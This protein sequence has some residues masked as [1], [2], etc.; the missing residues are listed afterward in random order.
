VLIVVEILSVCFNLLYLLY[1]IRQ[2]P[3]TW[4][5]GVIA[6]LLSFYLFYRMEYPASAV[7]NIIY[8]LQGIFGFLQWEFFQKKRIPGFYLSPLHHI[9][10]I[11]SVVISFLA[12]NSFFGAYFPGPLRKFDLFLAL[13]CISTTFLEI[14]K[15]TSCWYYWITLNFAFAGLYG[16]QQLYWYSALMFILCIFSIWALRE[17]RRESPVND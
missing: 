16:I 13:A 14:R 8:A 5:F 3:I 6:S 7:L 1:A 15:D 12:L 2:K 4:I 11:I 10:I 17:W 9:F